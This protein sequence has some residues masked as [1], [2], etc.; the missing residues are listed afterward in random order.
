[1]GPDQAGLCYCKETGGEA[2]S[3]SAG[4]AGEGGLEA[5]ATGHPTERAGSAGEGR[6]RRVRGWWVA[7]ISTRCT[8]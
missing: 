4:G 6:G 5:R 1:M 8:T 2:G 3:A 7:I